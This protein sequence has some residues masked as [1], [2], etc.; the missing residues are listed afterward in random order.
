MSKPYILIFPGQGTHLAGMGQFWSKEST[1][2]RECYH[3]LLQYFEKQYGTSLEDII[4]H[5]PDQ[6]EQTQWAQPAIYCYQVAAAKMIMHKKKPSAVAGHSLGEFAAVVAAGGMDAYQTLDL[7]AQRGALM[8]K[9]EPGKMIAVLSTQDVVS[10]ILERH[11]KW[12]CWISAENDH[13][14]T[15][16]SGFP[17][18]IALFANSLAYLG[19]R[20]LNVPIENAFHTPIMESIAEEWKLIAQSIKCKTFDIQLYSSVDGKKHAALPHDYWFMHMFARVR[21]K[22]ALDNLYQDFPDHTCIEVGPGNKFYSY[23]KKRWNN[24]TSTGPEKNGKELRIQL[25]ELLYHT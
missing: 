14:M 10:N 21:F 24:I 22:Q 2:F 1:I 15:I 17:D 4:N 3:S 18:D 7:V 20:Y 16:V 5:K 6:L 23:L 13:T 11:P 9:T 19:I 12:A 25:D 8:Q